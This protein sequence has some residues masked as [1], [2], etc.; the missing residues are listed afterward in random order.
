MKLKQLLTPRF[1]VL[2]NERMT[3]LEIRNINSRVL[4]QNDTII[5]KDL[6]IGNTSLIILR[7]LLFQ[8]QQLTILF[9]Q[10]GLMVLFL[11]KSQT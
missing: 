1:T 8:K 7:I 9:L 10:K 11:F 3:L 4:E 6:L 5:T 2:D